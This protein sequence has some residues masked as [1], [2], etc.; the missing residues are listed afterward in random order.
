M[1]IIESKLAFE[2]LLNLRIQNVKDEMDL[3]MESL[4]YELDEIYE[5][6]NKQLSECKKNVME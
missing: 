1:Q 4:K 6:F 5:E 3:K 2:E